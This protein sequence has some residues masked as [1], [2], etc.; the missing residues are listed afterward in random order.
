M[1]QKYE[2]L[3]KKFNGVLK[4]MPMRGKRIIEERPPKSND[5]DDEDDYASNQR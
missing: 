2:E 1:Q 5:S 4:D 3:K